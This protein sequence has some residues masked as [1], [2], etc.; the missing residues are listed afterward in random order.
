MNEKMCCGFFIYLFN[1]FNKDD[2]EDD[3]GKRKFK[4]NKKTF[5]SWN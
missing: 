4:K 3:G 2:D 1:H 5:H